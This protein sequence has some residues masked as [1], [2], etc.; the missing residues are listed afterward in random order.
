MQNWRLRANCLDQNTEGFYPPRDKD[1]YRTVADSA[2]KICYSGA[3]G[4]TPC[5]VRQEC[6]NFALTHDEKYGIWG[7]LSHRE[8]N[9][10]VRRAE[11]LNVPWTTLIK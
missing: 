11:R 1:K 9:A 7:G 5:P 8:R 2:K 6:L 4:S 10:M 3:D